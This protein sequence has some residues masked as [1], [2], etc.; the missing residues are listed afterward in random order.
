MHRFLGLALVLGGMVGGWLLGEPTTSEPVAELTPAASWKLYRAELL[1]AQQFKHD[2]PPHPAM[3]A[4][5]LAT[6]CM[7]VM[8]VAA[9]EPRRAMAVA[10]GLER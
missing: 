1:A 4:L 10:I 9:Q 2:I 8:L 6:A 7:G 5:M 3:V